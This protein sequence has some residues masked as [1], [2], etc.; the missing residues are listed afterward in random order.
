MLRIHPIVSSLSRHKLM[1]W[2]ICLQVAITCGIVS[3]IVF[4]IANRVEQAMLPSG[5]AEA[6][7]SIIHSTFIG[8]SG[9]PPSLRALQTR[10]LAALRRIPGVTAAAAVDDSLPLDQDDSSL[11]TCASAAA[12][13]GAR[14]AMGP[15]VPGCVEP[16]VYSG[17]PGLLSTLGMHL[18]EG[19]DFLP[20]EYVLSNPHGPDTPPAVIISRSLAHVLFPGED[21]V[22]QFIFTFAGQPIR[23]VG[24][25]DRL[26][27]P[28]L[29]KPGAEYYSMLWSLLPGN[30]SV[31]YVLRSTHRDRRAVL[32]AAA[33]TL[34][35]LEHQRI[36]GHA[37]TYSQAR[38]RYFRDDANMIGLLV[39]STVALVLVTAIG[40]MG[41]ASFWAQQRVRQIGI[42]RAVGARRRDILWQFQAENLIIVGVGAGLGLVIG[43][44]LNMLLM[45]VYAVPKLPDRYLVIGA[46]S[47]LVIGQLSVLGPALRA[48]STPPAVATR[49]V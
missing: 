9:G 39:A 5:I 18:V 33:T 21:A 25:V 4:M 42:R 6:E 30:T 47:M 11:T 36:L 27:R 44:A 26:L 15:R 35:D 14:Q 43:V 2:L 41:L 17:T 8:K 34:T 31:T 19:R 38:R 1:V 16:S 32:K 48:A 49:N 46:L 3:N 24:V 40:I 7:L 22:G 28:S 10:D 29:H 37:Q 12:L 45:R 20:N 23:V 13:N